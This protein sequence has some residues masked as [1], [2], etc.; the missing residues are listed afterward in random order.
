MDARVKGAVVGVGFGDHG[1]A[2]AEVVRLTE[3]IA[4]LTWV[5]AALTVVNVAAVIYS[6]A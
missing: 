6:I 3:R 2:C 4:M 5:I 1:G